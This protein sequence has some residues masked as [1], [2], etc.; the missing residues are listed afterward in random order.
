MYA[1]FNGKL[2]EKTP[3]FAIVE[4]HG[5][6]Y[7]C[8]IPITLVSKL[9][10][11]GEQVLLYVSWVVREMSQALYGFATQEQRDLFE[12]LLTLSGIGPKTAL[13]LVGHF[14]LEDLEESVRTGNSQSLTQVP[15][16]GKKTAERLIVDLKGKL[17]F[18]PFPK[19]AVTSSKVQDALNAL[20]HLGCSQAHAEQAIKKAMEELTE[21]CD[22]PT[23]ITAALK[24]Q[25]RL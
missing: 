2:V 16:I 4:V 1:Y 19:S 17:K 25:R 3:L 7:K 20:L 18:S 11:V 10:P 14:E 6:G 13:A 9:P 5:I 15:G 21:E 22:L 24:Y 23:L 8:H 12:L